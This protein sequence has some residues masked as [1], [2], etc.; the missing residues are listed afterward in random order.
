MAIR[1]AIK[2]T[3]RYFTL[4]KQKSRALAVIKRYRKK[5][6]GYK[7]AHAK[8]VKASTAIHEAK[9]KKS[10]AIR[11][12]KSKPFTTAIKNIQAKVAK[13]NTELKRLNN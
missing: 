3:Y 11:K 10:I 2:R 7:K 9:I 1:K 4:Q 13:W 8:R 6:E 5:V 12:R